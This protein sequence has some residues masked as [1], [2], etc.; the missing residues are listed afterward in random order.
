M[1]DMLNHLM[2]ILQCVQKS[3]YPISQGEKT[4]IIKLFS[5]ALFK[6]FAASFISTRK[7]DSPPARLSLAPTR[8][9]NLSTIDNVDALPSVK[10]RMT[11]IPN[12]KDIVPL[13]NQLLEIDFINTIITAQIDTIA[14]AGQG[15]SSAYTAIGTTADTKSY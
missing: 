14:V 10:I 13:R 12:S 9:N 7:V 6:I 5:V 2:V 15:G 1:I 4:N 8:V 3:Y 11:V